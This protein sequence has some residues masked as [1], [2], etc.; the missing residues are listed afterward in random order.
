MDCN[1]ENKTKCLY[2]KCIKNLDLKSAK[3]G[4]EFYYENLTFCL[5]DVVFSMGIKYN[6]VQN[7][8]IRYKNYI[9]NNGFNFNDHKI[10]DFIKIVDSFSCEESDKFLIFSEK[11]LTKNQ[12]LPKMEFLRQ[13]LV[14]KLQ[15]YWWKII[16]KPKNSLI[17]CLKI[18]WSQ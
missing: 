4:D 16:L 1:I 17:L 2:E 7:A 6:I 14:T 18:L 3:L 13:K 10:S 11:V 15:K 8:I 5:I 9:A 12:H